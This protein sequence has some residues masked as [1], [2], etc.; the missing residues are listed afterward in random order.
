M[1]NN[2]TQ[3][4]TKT[5]KHKHSHTHTLKNM[6]LQAAE[7]CMRIPQT[8]RKRPTKT[9]TNGG[10]STELGVP[11]PRLTTIRE[12]LQYQEDTVLKFMITNA[13]LWLNHPPSPAQQRLPDCLPATLSSG[14][15]TSMFQMELRCLCR[16]ILWSAAFLFIHKPYCCR[17]P[18]SVPSLMD[19]SERKQKEHVPTTGDG[20]LDLSRSWLLLLTM[21]A[22]PWSTVKR[23][24][25]SALGG[26]KNHRRE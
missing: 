26:E 20:E 3:R 10:V 2:T 12:Q 14:L 4:N 9:K 24:G 7:L 1:N 25:G 5:I 8:P 11:C 13:L 23:L 22:L 6:K 16:A 21:T 15:L 19:V 17:S 18:P